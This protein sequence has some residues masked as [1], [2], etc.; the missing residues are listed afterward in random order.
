MASVKMSIGRISSDI[1]YDTRRYRFQMLCQADKAS[2]T[3]NSSDFVRWYTG[4]QQKIPRL[5]W[6]GIVYLAAISQET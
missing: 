6:S 4:A 3:Q 1:L 5:P 2:H